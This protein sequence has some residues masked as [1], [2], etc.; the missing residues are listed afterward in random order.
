[1]YYL[2]QR[3]YLDKY[4]SV[5]ENCQ[6]MVISF[7]CNNWGRNWSCDEGLKL[8]FSLNV[9]RKR[10]RIT[11]LCVDHRSFRHAYL[12]RHSQGLLQE[13]S[14]ST[15]KAESF[16]QGTSK[17]RQPHPQLQLTTQ[18]HVF[19]RNDSTN[20]NRCCHKKIIF[21]SSSLIE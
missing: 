7:Y 19:E 16:R 2:F 10:L 12:S 1:M 8:C 17:V 15:T 9:E 4:K 14:V 20:S 6:I 21:G 13:Q 11:A 18:A 3:A 5:A